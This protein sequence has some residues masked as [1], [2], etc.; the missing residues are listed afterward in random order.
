MRRRVITILAFPILAYIFL[1]G[2]ALYCTGS[3]KASLPQK[4]A[5]K[6]TITEKQAESTA[7]EG[8]QMGLIEEEEIINS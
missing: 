1:I 7:D 6:S 8:I 5:K 4:T 3:K 2:W